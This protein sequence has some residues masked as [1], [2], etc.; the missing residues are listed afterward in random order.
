MKIKLLAIFIA[1]FAAVSCSD[2]QKSKISED[3]SSVEEQPVQP[4]EEEIAQEPEASD[5]EGTDAY[6]VGTLSCALQFTS[7]WTG[8]LEAG[9]W[10]G[11]GARTYCRAYQRQN[12]PTYDKYDCKCEKI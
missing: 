10:L 3:P 9:A 8:T 2:E 4:E 11:D 7:F 5:E 12:S 1:L 6:G